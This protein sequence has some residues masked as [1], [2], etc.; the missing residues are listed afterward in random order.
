MDLLTIFK[1]LKGRSF[2]LRIIQAKLRLGKNDKVKG[3]DALFKKYAQIPSTKD[4][5]GNTLESEFKELY[6][7][8]LFYGTK[9]VIMFSL[10]KNEARFL[11]NKLSAFDY[12]SS[13]FRKTYP[14]PLSEDDLKIQSSN[15]IPTAY[16]EE[17][18]IFRVISC[19]KRTVKTSE[20]INYEIFDSS[21]KEALKEY[22]EVV[23]RKSIFYQSF[24]NLIIYPNDNR[25]DIHIDLSKPWGTDNFFNLADLK[26]SIEAHIKLLHKLGV[27]LEKPKNFLPCIPKLYEE[28]AG[29][30]H[31]LGHSTGT[32][33][34]KDEKMNKKQLDI[35]LKKELFHEEGLKAIG[36]ST[37]YFAITKV[38]KSVHD[39][40]LPELIIEGKSA[41][42]GG[43]NASVTHAIIGGCYCKED[44]EMVISKLLQ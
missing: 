17:N 21:V 15:L 10:Q 35:N 20:F 16:Y 40:G 14:L 8:H 33:S 44:F 43:L 2:S 28:E 19:A 42:A 9:A 30:I 6:L 27:T 25:L 3:W 41:G 24:D 38:W 26:K 18:N 7:N 37:N 31:K 23:V 34:T 22:D 39:F 1:A 12:E 13:F 29:A 11:I 32:D 5:F 4:I 36:G